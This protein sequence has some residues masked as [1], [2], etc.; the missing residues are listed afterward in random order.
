MRIRALGLGVPLVIA[1][2]VVAPLAIEAQQSRKV[3]RVGYISPGS[4]PDALTETFRQG[5]REF[6]YVERQNLVIEYRWTGL[7]EPLAK[8]AAGLVGLKPYLIVSVSQRVSLE[9]KRATTTIPSIFAPL[10]D[11]SDVR[12][13]PM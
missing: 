3:Y 13:Y 10:T 11:P 6:G 8:L 4:G 2:L 5:L 7:G 12:L 9:G 1:L